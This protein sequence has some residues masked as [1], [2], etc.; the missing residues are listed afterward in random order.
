MS[1][2]SHGKINDSFLTENKYIFKKYKLIKLIDKGNCGKIYS[3][4]NI[5]DSNP[6]AMKTEKKT[7]RY[8]TLE[9][10][11]YFL[12]ILQGFGIPKLITYGQTKN[13]NILIETL[14]DKSLDSIFIKKQKKCSIIEL[15]LIAIQ[16]LDR[17]E[18][19]HSKDIIYRDVKPQHFLFGINDPNVIYIVDFG[20]CKKY[21]SSK[22]GKHILPRLTKKF[23]GTLSYASPN[24]TKGK[25]SSRRDDLISLGYVLIKLLK[26]DLPW[27]TN[28]KEINGKL[29]DKLF[30]LKITD[31][32]G[33][34]FEG[35]P[36]ELIDYVKYCKN[37]KF[38]EDPNYSYL[39]SLFNKII[40]KKSLNYITFSWINNNNI[41]NKKLIGLPKNS[42]RHSN[43]RYRLLKNIKEQRKRRVISD[44]LTI[45]NK[46][47]IPQDFSLFNHKKNLT[48]ET[49]DNL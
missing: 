16:L 2:N 23:T 43:L 22:T 7:E 9:S 10:E 41:N 21:R 24:V 14:L 6:F 15:S 34:L 40:I 18:W 33:K 12:L 5:K 26:G 49:S 46:D 45:P 27:A 19:I 32:N 11:A 13:Y 8:I 3:V 25:E 48:V 29:F 39:R 17:L 35:I 30:Y 4:I 38:E 1:S 42:S 47:N 44:S 31:G 28:F 37:L 20:I 36:E